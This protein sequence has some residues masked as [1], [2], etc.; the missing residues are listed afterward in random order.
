MASLITIVAIAELAAVRWVSHWL[1]D[2]ASRSTEGIDEEI[3]RW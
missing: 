2:I 1:L 3:R